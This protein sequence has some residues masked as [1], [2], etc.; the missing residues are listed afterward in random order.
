MRILKSRFDPSRAQ[1]CMRFNLSSP[2]SEISRVGKTVAAQ[3]KHLGVLTIKDLLF[4]FPSRHDDLSKITPIGQALVGQR[5]VL[6]GKIELIENKRSKYRKRLLIHALVSDA[7]GSIRVVWFNQPWIVKMF[8]PGDELYLVGEVKDDGSGSVLSSPVYE[9]VSRRGPTHTARLV[10]VYPSTEKLSQKQIRFLVKTVLTLSKSVPDPLPED[11][12]SSYNLA[13]LPEALS[14]IHFPPNEEQLEIAKRRL[15]FDE[16]FRLQ[17]FAGSLKRELKKLPAPEVAFEEK[18]TKQFVDNLPFKLTDDQRKASWEIIKDMEKTRPMNRLLE[19]DVG[20]GK[21]VVIA[22]AALNCA[23]AKGQ[24]AIMA[25]TEILARQHFDTFSEF[26]TPHGISVSLRTS[27]NKGRSASLKDDVVIG[28]HALIQKTV[29]FENLVLAV[30]DEQHRFGV[31]QRKTLK[32]KREDGKM[33]HLLTLTATPIPRSLALVF[34]GDLDISILREM[35]KGRKK[36]ETRMI[37]PDEHEQAYEFVR[38]EVKTGHQVFWTC[39]I[40]D[41]SDKLGVKAATE[42]FEYLKNEV[43]NDLN[44]GLL[45]GRMKSKEREQVMGEFQD[46]KV[47]IL[48]ATPVIEV[49]IDVPNATIMV[50]EGAQRFGLAQL[51]QF[52]GRVGRGEAQSHC[53]L[54]IDE[55]AMAKEATQARLHAFLQSQDGF[56]LAEQD[57]ELRGPGEVYGK[58]Q[59][60]FPEFKIASFADVDIAKQAKQA[61]EALLSKDPELI[62]YPE[63]KQAVMDR[64]GETHL[65]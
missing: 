3:L 50:I 60:G 59:S 19:G 11:I 9:K 64:E 52:R 55:D 63:L 51:H 58:A 12:R 33:P 27:A 10:P 35:P 36:I 45:H 54:F 39:P 8:K 15:K 22:L 25:P 1:R 56:D 21:T 24:A 37:G 47:D 48:V 23:L 57:L 20:S 30:V 29:K 42:V 7:S 5:V 4:Y 18:Q 17:L 65:E 34:Y 61:A 16:L 41:P 40:I 13:Q 38:K 2:A 28:T 46:K 43:F 49:G 14:S 53:L 44:V 26:L 6:R 32:Q 31:E 62:K